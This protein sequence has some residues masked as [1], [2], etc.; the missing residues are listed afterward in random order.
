MRIYCIF[1][2]CFISLF[3]HHP[4]LTE[5]TRRIN[6]DTT[7]RMNY[8]VGALVNLINGFHSVL[9]STMQ[10]WKTV[11]PG[12]YFGEPFLSVSLSLFDHPHNDNMVYEKHRPTRICI[13]LPP[14]TIF[15]HTHIRIH[16]K[17]RGLGRGNFNHFKKGSINLCFN[18]ILRLIIEFAFLQ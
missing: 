8:S 18:P 1:Y 6:G 17:F 11:V 5:R 4:H 15:G 13:R 7:L 3:C 10:I 14:G 12:K 9:L 16:G 2:R